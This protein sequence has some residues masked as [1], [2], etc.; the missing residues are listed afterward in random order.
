MVLII[1][2]LVVVALLLGAG[3]AAFL[4]IVISIHEVDR[5]KGL[6]DAP[7][8]YADAATRRILGASRRADACRCERQG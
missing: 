1:L 4:M 8:T 7:C 6:A 5:S 2:T 3:V